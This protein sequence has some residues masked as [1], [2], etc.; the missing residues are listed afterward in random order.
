[1]IVQPDPAQ[2][3][4]RVRRSQGPDSRLVGRRRPDSTLPHGQGGRRLSHVARRG[5]RVVVSHGEE[6]APRSLPPSELFI[7]WAQH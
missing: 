6:L 4:L 5:V 7:V 3:L 1:M 2:G